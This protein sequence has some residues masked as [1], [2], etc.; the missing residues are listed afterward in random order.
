MTK[1]TSLFLVIAFIIGSCTQKKCLE[2]T[3]NQKITKESLELE[4]NNIQPGSMSKSEISTTIKNGSKVPI[5]LM[6]I[7]IS[8]G[9]NKDDNPLL[10]PLVVSKEKNGELSSVSYSK[11]GWIYMTNP[12]GETGITI[13]PDANYILNLPFFSNAAQDCFS[14]NITIKDRKLL[15]FGPIQITYPPNDNQ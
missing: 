3:L 8:V 15:E 4:F 1:I 6:G 14:I 11:D 7:T 5:I 2:I 10:V 9:A 13:D 12:R